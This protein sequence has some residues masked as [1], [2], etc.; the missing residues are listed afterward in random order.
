MAYNSIEN[1][2]AK[3]K[4]PW[5]YSFDF[6]CDKI[7]EKFKPKEK[8]FERYFTLKASVLD[9]YSG[10]DKAYPEAEAFIKKLHDEGYTKEFDCDSCLL[11][12]EIYSVLWSGS[13]MGGDTMNSAHKRLVKVIV[14]LNTSKKARLCKGGRVNSRKYLTQCFIGENGNEFTSELEKINGLREY[15]NSYHLLGNFVLVPAGFNMYRATQFDDYWDR[16]LECLK[17][18]QFDKGKFNWYIN[19]FF[20]WDYV[21]ADKYGYTVKP[22]GSNK[23][24]AAKSLPD[25]F[26]KT[27]KIIERRGIFMTAMLRLRVQIG[28]DKYNALCETVFETDAA[29]SGYAAV[30][31]EIV[32]WLKLKKIDLPD[33][34]EAAFKEIKR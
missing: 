32:K 9:E 18:A 28:D 29:Y 11:M 1:L 30:I 31:D 26:T 7:A 17:M 6:E 10:E 2:L 25:F 19:Y 12:N 21:E 24:S 5:N 13:S 8:V 33:N 34:V 22:I 23:L 4:E 16:S 20:L 15:L 14:R 3:E 27:M